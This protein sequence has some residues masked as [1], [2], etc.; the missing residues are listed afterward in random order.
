M[1]KKQSTIS[2]VFSIIFILVSIFVIYKLFTIYKTYS[3]YGFTKAEFKLGTSEFKRDFENKYGEHASYKIK[4]AEFN[5]AMFYKE[6]EVTPNTPYRVTCMVKTENIEPEIINSDAGANISIL[7]STEISRSIT[8]TNDWQKIELIFNSKNRTSVIIGF[9]IGG[10]G[11]NCKGTAWFSDLKVESGNAI[12]DSNW[13][14][15]CFIFEEIDVT[16]EDGKNYNFKMDLDDIER[17]N[18]NLKRFQSS[19]SELSNR[20]LSVTYDIHNIETPVNTISYSEEHGYYVGPNDVRHL[21]SDIVFENGY[22]HIFIIVRMGN[23]ED[24]IKVN[25]WIGLGGMDLYDIGFST[26][27]LPNSSESYEQKYDYRINTFPEEVYIHEFLHTLERD[28]KEYGYSVP[29]LHDHEVYGYEE[30]FAENLKQWYKD[31]MRKNVYDEKTG[32]YIGLDERI[33]SMKPANSTNFMY[34]MEIEF[35]EEPENIIEEIRAM[36]AT[37][38]NNANYN[39]EGTNNESIRF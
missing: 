18:N 1:S 10:N 21:I 27:R 36:F 9:R 38:G 17:T 11:S 35:E 2:K 23:D 39:K 14:I 5:D 31:Y 34:P 6:V 25:D 33:F 19:C 4:S 13:N 22:N 26:I 20:K 3:F 24:E 16:L 32:T 30:D 37:I 29:A 28:S 12:S 7:D 8:G 15:G